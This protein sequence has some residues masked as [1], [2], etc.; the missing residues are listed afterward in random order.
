M[1]RNLGYLSTFA[2]VKITLHI[3]RQDLRGGTN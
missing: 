1:L 2:I 3:Y